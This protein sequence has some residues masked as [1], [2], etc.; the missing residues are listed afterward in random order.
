MACELIRDDEGKV[1]AIACG[2]PWGIGTYYHCH[3]E[4]CFCGGQ[5]VYGFPPRAMNPEDFTP[6]TESCMPAEIDSWKE[7]LAAWQKATE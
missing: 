2:S 1:I 5:A 6:D 3:D 4:A 7:A